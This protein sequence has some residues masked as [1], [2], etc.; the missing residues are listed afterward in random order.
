M[1]IKDYVKLPLKFIFWNKL[2]SLIII[3]FLFLIFILGH[4]L[5]NVG[6][7]YDKYV[8]DSVN[9]NILARTYFI[10]NSEQ[11]AGEKTDLEKIVFDVRKIPHVIHSYNDQYATLMTANIDEVNSKNEDKALYIKTVTDNFSPSIS[12]GRKI[13]NENEIICPRFLK[14]SNDAK[15]K[16]DV[17][18]MEKYLNKEITLSYYQLYWETASKANIAKNFQKKVR[19]VGI[20]DNVLSLETYNECYMKEEVVRNMFLESESIYSEEF[21]IGN[22]VYND[23]NATEVV[24]DELKNMDI[25]KNELI[26]AG[27]DVS[28]VGLSFDW[29][30]INKVK[31]ISLIVFFVLLIVIFIVFGI[32]INIFFKKQKNSI[33]LYKNFGY[34]NH[35]LSTLYKIQILYYSLISFAM[36]LIMS[37]IGVTIANRIISYNLDYFY[38]RLSVSI[39]L[40]FIFLFFIIGIICLVSGKINKKIN[41][42]EIR[43]IFNEDSI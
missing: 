43:E 1:K 31:K 16:K 32:Y 11:L 42:F 26:K 15:S 5:I 20:F 23:G 40:E 27:Y 29:K 7:N 28:D 14:T 2:S 39:Y 17:V 10:F 25:V 21:L 37:L 41:S 9:K 38:V 34:S 8:N 35:Q 4:I 19:L 12:L 24:V 30:F 6:Y 18:S 22:Y 13:N 36:S 33:A 3:I